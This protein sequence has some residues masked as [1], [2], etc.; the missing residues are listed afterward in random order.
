[1][2][3]GT[4]LG[5]QVFR[6]GTFAK[7]DRVGFRSPPPAGNSRPQPLNSV[8]GTVRTSGLLSIKSIERP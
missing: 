4:A 2:G 6:R 3:H 7:D 5:V 8:S 1:M